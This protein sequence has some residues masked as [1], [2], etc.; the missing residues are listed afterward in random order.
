MKKSCITGISSNW[1]DD[2]PYSWSEPAYHP[3]TE[4]YKNAPVCPGRDG[5][6]H[7]NL[8]CPVDVNEQPGGSLPDIQSLKAAKTFLLEHRKKVKKGNKK[9]FLLAVGFHKPHVPLKYPMKYRGKCSFHFSRVQHRSYL[10]YVKC[11][12]RAATDKSVL[13]MNICHIIFSYFIY[14]KGENYLIYVPNVI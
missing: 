9:P 7:K 10:L 13:S 14:I 1:S 6:L 2:N 4:Q 5:R 12:A 3:P 8:L 11:L